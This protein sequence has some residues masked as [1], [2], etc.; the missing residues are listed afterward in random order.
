[1][2][3]FE[4]SEFFGA[5]DHFKKDV[6]Q[7]KKFLQDL[8]LLVVKNHLPI[9]FIE[10]TWLK[11]LVMHLCSR[12]VFTSRKIFSQEVLVDLVEKMKQKYVLPKLKQCYFA[13]SCDLWMSKGTHDVFILVIGFLN[14]EWQP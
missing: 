14:E 7:Q 8:A 6:V 5:K 1:V 2:S 10:S 11:F 13:T 12:V 4:I 9:Q 3:N